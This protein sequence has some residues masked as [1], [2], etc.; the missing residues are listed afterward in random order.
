MT[1][2]I[3]AVF[4]VSENRQRTAAAVSP[5]GSLPPPFVPHRCVLILGANPKSLPRK[6]RRIMLQMGMLR[7]CRGPHAPNC[8]RHTLWGSMAFRQSATRKNVQAQSWTTSVHGSAYTNLP[9]GTKCADATR[10]KLQWPIVVRRA[11]GCGQLYSRVDE[12]V[13]GIVVVDGGRG[14]VA[15]TAQGW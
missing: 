9:E 13:V 14:I 10:R 5:W 3:C 11:S 7:V 12:V 2:P 8:N 6:S 15:L 4:G 1:A